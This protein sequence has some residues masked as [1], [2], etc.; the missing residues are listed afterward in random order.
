LFDP[1]GFRR[2]D[3]PCFAVVR[4][5]TFKGHSNVL[6][7]GPDE[8]RAARRDD[9]EQET[10]AGITDLIERYADHRFFQV[11][12]VRRTALIDVAAVLKGL[13]PP[14]GNAR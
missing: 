1:I 3:L 13:K 2:D 14:Y 4:W 7:F 8:D 6:L 10:R 11:R 12:A 5:L 9:D